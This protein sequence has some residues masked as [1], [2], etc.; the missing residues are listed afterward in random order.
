MNVT[1]R[2]PAAPPM[3]RKE[4]KRLELHG[5]VRIDD[6]FWL[7]D[8]K[9]PE[10]IAY[11]EAENRYT[12]EQMRSVEGLR[13]KLYREI[14]GRIQET[15]T[16]VPAK[17]GDYYYYTRTEQGKEY[18]ISC[19]KKGS[20]DAP[21]EV[22]LDSNLLADGH[23]YFRL[24]VFEVSP[25]HRLLAYSIDTVGDETYTL[26]IKN[27]DTGELLA[28]RIFNT[29]YSVE[30]ANDN[31]TI[32]YNVVEPS[33][34][35]PF[36]VF[37]H[38]LGTPAE[39]DKLVYHE[40]DEAFTLNIGKSRSRDYLFLVLDSATTTEIRY[41]R[42]DNP[43][44]A[45][46]TLLARRHDIE[47]DVEHH[48]DW[49][50]LR[51]NDTGRNFRLVRTPVSNPSPDA[52]QEVIR[53]RPDVLLESVDAFRDHL[54]IVERHQ[55]LRR[56]RID[57]LQDGS[58]HYVDF[59]EPTY[60][61]FPT[62]NY[63]FDTRLL[64]FT[65][66][67]LVTPDSVFDYDMTARTM[68][69]KKRTP[70]LGGYDPSQYRSERLYAT[71]PDGVQVPISLVYRAGLVKN[72]R[73]PTL[74]YGYGAYGH[75]IDPSFSSDRLSLLDR[76]FVYA[77]AHIRGGSELGKPWHDDG[78]MLRKKNTFTDFIACAEHLICEQYTSPERLAAM[79]GSAGGLLMGAVLNFRP[80]LFHA[81]I[82]KVPFVDIINTMLDPTLPLTVGEYEEWGNPLDP[83]Y[84][85]Y[86]R[87]YS[88][89]DNLTERAY[90]H[91]LVTAGLNDPRVS[92]WEPAKWTAKMRTLKRDNT[93]LLLKTNMGAGH[94]GASGRY[95]RMKETAFEYAFLLKVFGIT[96]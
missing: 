20:V 48:S 55:G 12:E 16:S 41:L 9:N 44:G 30:W 79:G 82:A 11:L 23:A 58:S 90:P 32:F 89:Y 17:I 26:F 91:I 19:R 18:S 28:D 40:P 93:L 77:I 31:E 34:K 85:A 5:D 96:E 65:Y 27:L 86:M 57:S 59:P 6:Y 88:P 83:E 63:E 36:Q 66:S 69:L 87:S 22:L 73:N 54:A 70:V 94:F 84:Y 38:R 61:V 14:V 64:R 29:Y 80:D 7:R 50:Y 76:G 51:I 24:G 3:A 81:I 75:S 1:L 74:L 92:Y 47:Y 49:F 8:R 33:T 37:R 53:H 67:S 42:A 2:T 60:T 78:K 25:N 46:Q 72:G 39:E 35:R 68:E 56:I 15:D 43:E 13:E 52:W 10:V 62:S 71:A 21:E 45:F 4:P 95:E